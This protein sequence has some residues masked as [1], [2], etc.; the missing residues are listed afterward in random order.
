M[1]VSTVN[2]VGNLYCLDV[3]YD[4]FALMYSCRNVDSN[5]MQGLFYII[6][7]VSSLYGFLDIG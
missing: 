4:D 5:R 7:T 2:V 3:D 1:I 6:F